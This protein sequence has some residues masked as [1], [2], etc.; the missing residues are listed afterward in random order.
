MDF[1]HGIEGSGLLGRVT[2]HAKIGGSMKHDVSL[3]SSLFLHVSESEIT[4]FQLAGS[5]PKP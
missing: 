4:R 1:G 5:Y 3:W 2:V